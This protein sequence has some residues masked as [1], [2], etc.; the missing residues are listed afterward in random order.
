MNPDDKNTEDKNPL[1]NMLDQ[2][3]KLLKFIQEKSTTQINEKNL[4]PEVY[5]QLEK[6]KQDVQN[7]K[8]IGDSIVSLS[9]VPREELKKRLVGR[10]EN[11]PVEGKR[12]IDRGQNLKSQVN[13]M[14]ENLN[15]PQTAPLDG[16]L[17][18]TAAKEETESPEEGK[19]SSARRRRKFKRFGG[20]ANWRPL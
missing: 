15:L 14:R 13:E 12:V 11:L 7:F 19:K 6:L 9:E 17:P 8:K 3:S 5:E 4:T 20:D 10:S 2:L 1:E 18:S 16:N